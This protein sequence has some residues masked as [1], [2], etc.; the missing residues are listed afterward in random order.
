MDH[1]TVTARPRTRRKWETVVQEI[2]GRHPH[3]ANPQWVA[4]L[5][6][7]ERLGTILRDVLGPEEAARL[8]DTDYTTEPFGVALRNIAAAQNLSVR[9]IARRCN[10]S[11]SE[12]NRWLNENKTP[13]ASNLADAARAVGKPDAYFAEHRA[14]AVAA[15]VAAFLE[16]NPDRSATVYSQLAKGAR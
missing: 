8:L 6:D 3:L 15:A 14:N 11:K 12:V 5:N 16:A 7:M 4:A 2:L 10:V 9:E 1:K 13:S